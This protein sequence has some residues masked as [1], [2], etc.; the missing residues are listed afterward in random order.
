[1]LS[2]SN[3]KLEKMLTKAYYNLS[4]KSS[5]YDFL[6]YF[7]LLFYSFNFL[8]SLIYFDKSLF[9][10]LIYFSIIDVST[11]DYS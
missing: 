4:L 8:F 11:F 10:S 1:M 5:I 6:S 2:L 9:K 7:Y 3:C